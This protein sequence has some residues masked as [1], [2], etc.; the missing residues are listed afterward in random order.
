M[1]EKN[2]TPEPIEEETEIEV[3]ENEKEIKDEPFEIEEPKVRKSPKDY[4]LER[5]SQRLAKLEEERL[6]NNFD[7]DE[8]ENDLQTIVAKELDKRLK[9]L[10]ET[11]GNQSFQQELQEVL[12]TY[13]GLKGNEEAIKKYA[14]AYPDTPLEFI[15][16]GILFKKMS[17]ENGRE[18]A[19]LK[20]KSEQKG[21]NVKRPK[22]VKEKNA[23][24][25]S[26][27]EFLET[28]NKVRSGLY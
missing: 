21:G 8:D 1:E 19:Q 6:N 23:W 18:E 22:I 7:D 28:T 11:L 4:I 9:P 17:K 26:E 2:I 15:A 16:Q 14:Q 3:A 5:R 10:S 25:M 13:P 20:A 12:T 27:A 24:E